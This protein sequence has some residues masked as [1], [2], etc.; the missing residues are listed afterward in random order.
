MRRHTNLTFVVITAFSD[1]AYLPRWK[2]ELV[3]VAQEE[4]FW[5]T[6]VWR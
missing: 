5:G 1:M 3:A 2:V 6:G 4:L